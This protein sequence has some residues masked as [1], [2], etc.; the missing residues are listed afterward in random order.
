MFTLPDVLYRI[1]K[2]TL[3]YFYLHVSHESNR[4]SKLNLTRPCI[5][6]ILDGEKQIFADNKFDR[7]HK[8]D[9]VLLN[10]G[11]YLT[12]E[13]FEIEQNYKSLLIFFDPKQIIPFQQNNKVSETKFEIHKADEYLSHFGRSC[14]MLFQ[15]DIGKAN[16]SM[17]AVK[18]QEFL[19]YTAHKH[20]DL[21]SFFYKEER[22]L[23]DENF[24]QCIERYWN[25]TLSVEEIAFLCNMSLSSF[26]RI[27]EKV[28]FKSPGRWLKQKRL[29]HAAVQIKSFNRNP[30]D[31]YVESGYADYSSFSYS[32]KKQ[33]GVCPKTY[34]STLR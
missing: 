16:V 10:P 27:F 22:S 23:K 33:F 28:Y 18:F 24:K 31:V 25:S 17:H 6:I 5:A 29:E 7:F 30:T 2:P 4:K 19:E 34:R 9:M 12:Y 14:Q 15:D 1:Q 32:F 11:N 20:L 21:L 13:I 8:G 3:P 26:K